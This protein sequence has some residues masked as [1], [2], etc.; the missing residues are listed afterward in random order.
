MDTGERYRVVSGYD[1]RDIKRGLTWDEAQELAREVG[2]LVDYPPL[3]KQEPN[4]S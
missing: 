1:S 4:F 3:I 2:R